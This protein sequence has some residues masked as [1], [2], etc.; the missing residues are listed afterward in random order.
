MCDTGHM[1]P[2]P[3]ADEVGRPFRHEAIGH[4]FSA[5]NGDQ[6]RQAVA[7]SVVDQGK[8]TTDFPI[9]AD[10]GRLDEGAD[11]GIGAGEPFPFDGGDHLREFL[12]QEGDLLRSN[13]G[14]S[15]SSKRWEVVPRMETVS[16]GTISRRSLGGGSG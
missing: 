10:T 13:L 15:R 9:V 2:Q 6:P 7:A 5:G 11:A 1:E 12:D 8:T 16:L 3:S 4:E 14:I